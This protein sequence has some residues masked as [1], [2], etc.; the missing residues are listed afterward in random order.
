MTPEKLDAI[1][2]KQMP[3]AEKRA[4]AHF[5]VDSSHGVDSARDQVRGILRAV[6]AT[7]NRL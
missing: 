2:A 3:D 5:V 6:A 4:R 1:L 7:P